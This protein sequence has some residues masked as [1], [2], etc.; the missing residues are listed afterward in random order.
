MYTI[1]REHISLTKCQISSNTAFCRKNGIQYER[2]NKEDRPCTYTRN[3][4]A[5]SSRTATVEKQHELHILSV[6]VAL[7][8]QHAKRCTRLI[9]FIS[10]ACLADPYFSTL[11][12]VKCII[13]HLYL[14]GC[15]VCLMTVCFYLLFYN[16]S[17][18]GF[19]YFLCLFSCFVCLLSDRGVSSVPSENSSTGLKLYRGR[20]LPHSFQ[21]TNQ[22]SY[23]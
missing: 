7:V 15:I 21:F 18:Y 14:C 9:I 8:V 3:I 22:S 23:D 5:R 20:Y 13:T 12:S 6:S 1:H 19:K 2:P 11:S 16:S 10:V 17:T 4:E